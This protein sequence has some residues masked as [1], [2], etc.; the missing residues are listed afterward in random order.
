MHKQKTKQNI[1]VLLLDS[2][3]EFLGVSKECLKLQGNLNIETATSSNEALTKIETKTSK[4]DVIVCGHLT[5]TTDCFGLLKTLRGKGD[6]TPFIVFSP[7]SNEET[8]IKA[9]ELGANALIEKHGNPADT[10]PNLKKSIESLTNN[11]F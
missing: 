5:S 4:P 1:E 9:I 8:A 10:Y 6:T 11:G 7:D 3:T 2:D